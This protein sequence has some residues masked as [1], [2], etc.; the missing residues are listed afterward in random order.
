MHSEHWTGRATVQLHRCQSQK[1]PLRWFSRALFKMALANQVRQ[2]HVE[3]LLR[4]IPG[5]PLLSE[6]GPGTCTLALSPNARTLAHRQGK[7]GPG[8][9][10]AG[11]RRHPQALCSPSRRQAFAGNRVTQGGGQQ[12][13]PGGEEMLLLE[14]K[15]AR[16]TEF[17]IWLFQ[18]IFVCF[19]ERCTFRSIPHCSFFKLLFSAC[20]IWFITDVKKINSGIILYS[21]PPG[22]S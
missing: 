20:K 13:H 1:D 16:S 14:K 10:P 8:L 2:G 17:I 3:N 19:A 15:T 4:H 5:P 22:V 21:L 18:Q 7:K 12:G 9:W 6:R 11:T